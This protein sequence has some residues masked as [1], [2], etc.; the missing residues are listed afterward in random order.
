MT[1][2]P[3]VIK[4]M[5]ILLANA[6]P[7]K[8]VITKTVLHVESS[9]TGEAVRAVSNETISEPVTRSSTSRGKTLLMGRSLPAVADG[10]L[11][12]GALI[13]E[14]ALAPRF[15]IA[16]SPRVI[17]TVVVAISD[18]RGSMP[19]HSKNGTGG[20]TYVMSSG[21]RVSIT[22]FLQDQ[23]IGDWVALRRAV[24]IGLMYPPASNKY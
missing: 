2:K 16:Y 10:P 1:G 20:P 7:A 23:I 14:V 19:S 3:I 18:Q 5:L 13:I 4:P 24:R 6:S 8:V 17:T 11:V 12:L 15:S 21:T 22:L 9:A